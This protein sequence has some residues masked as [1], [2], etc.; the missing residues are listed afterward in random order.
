MKHLKNFNGL[1]WIDKNLKF[2]NQD[3]YWSLYDETKQNITLCLVDLMD[4]G[5]ICKPNALNIYTIEVRID[6]IDYQ[7]GIKFEDVKEPISWFLEV[8]NITISKY[9]YSAKVNIR[10][11]RGSK[12]DLNFDSSELDSIKVTDKISFIELKIN[13]TNI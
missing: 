9:N 8:N 2:K 4:K 7:K 5:M 3:D 12:L 11:S 6:P 1:T 13:L 10:I